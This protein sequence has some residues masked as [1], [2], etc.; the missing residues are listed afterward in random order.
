MDTIVC[1]SGIAFT[2]GPRGRGGHGPGKL[3]PLLTPSARHCYPF[4]SIKSLTSMPESYK[5]SNVNRRGLRSRGTPAVM[6]VIEG[7]IDAGLCLI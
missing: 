5:E 7:Q 6:V 1:Q 3:E 2:S 4:G